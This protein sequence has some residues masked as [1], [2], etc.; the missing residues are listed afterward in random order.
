MA[1]FSK[2]A[3]WM[4]RT[5]GDE[6][7]PIAEASIGVTDWGLTHSDI[8]YDVVP[9]LEGAFFRLEVY[10]ERFAASMK[11]FRLDPPQTMEDLKT[12]LPRMV[13]KSGLKDA[14]CAMV[15]SRGE[16]LIPGTRD[17]RECGNY[18]FAWV[19]PYVHVFPP[20]V[21]ARGAHIWISK[22]SRR[23]PEDSVNSRAKNYHWGDFT[24]GL[25]EAKDHGFDNTVL[26]DFEGN[27][28]EGPGF[29][30]C[31]LKGDTVV[32]SAHDVL[33][34]IS[35][36]TILEICEEVGLKAEARPLPL[37]EL[38]DADEV[39]LTTSSGGLVP[40]ARVDE[41]VFSNDAPGEDS[42]RLRE[43]YRDWTRRPEHRTEI[44][45]E[46]PE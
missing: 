35:R 1:D 17:P 29:N 28:T 24:A 13:A 18:M 33:H 11:S 9:V 38:L 36:R 43:V 4:P 3:A 44:D 27:V 5:H 2:G 8:T 46:A 15:C 21:A 20:P 39:F 23:I 34:G 22:S 31:A 41:R 32:T 12:A 37:D 25:L 7:I 14:Y 10:T 40:V 30:I 42:L 26:L 19:V 6:I 45:Y 16:P